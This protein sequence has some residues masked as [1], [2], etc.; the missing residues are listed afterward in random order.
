MQESFF[1][2]HPI[3][4]QLLLMLLISVGIIIL[5]F[6]G[7]RIYSRHGKVYELADLTMCPVDSLQRANPLK[8]E[9]VVLDSLYREGLGGGRIISQDPKPGTFIKKHRK[10]YVTT[11]AFRP[12]D[13]VVP[14]ITGGV[15]LRNAIAQ[16]EGVG[17]KGGTL[18]FVDSPFRNTIIEMTYKGKVIYAGQKLVNGAKVDLVVG[19]GDDPQKAYGV[20]PFV[21]GKKMD[22][23]RYEI[24][25]ASFN[26]GTEHFDGV[27][28]RASAVVY[29]QTPSY[30]GISRI[31]FGAKVELWYCDADEQ[32]I[33]KM[34][35]EY[36]IDSSAI[37]NPSVQVE[38]GSS[39]DDTPFE[40]EGFGW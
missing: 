2:R 16:L 34:V 9:F 24:L 4:T 40:D 23:V 19:L 30:D 11:T 13:A 31:P 18:K 22:R 27:K 8:L 29:K 20:V 28:D 12:D 33:N 5:V 17:L 26:V 14:D 38:W 1:R 10:I 39:S 6:I 3:V 36:T 37:T 7:I 15:T 21:I 32:K 35:T 25:S